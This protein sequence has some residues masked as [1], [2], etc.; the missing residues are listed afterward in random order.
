MIYHTHSGNRPSEDCGDPYT[1]DDLPLEVGKAT[2]ALAVH[3][4]HFDVIAV[5]G[6]SGVLPGVGVALHLGKPLAVLRKPGDDSHHSAMN[7]EG[8]IWIGGDVLPGVRVL[9]LDDFTACGETK[10]RIVGA[11]ARAGGTVV[12]Q[13][14][15]QDGQYRVLT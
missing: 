5:T 15:T 6:L 11:V 14:L 12:A 2:C 8:D 10:S 13:F 4:S 7:D 9:W 3:A 1:L